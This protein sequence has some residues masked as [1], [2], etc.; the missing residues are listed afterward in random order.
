[1]LQLF[2]FLV[3]LFCSSGILLTLLSN[4]TVITNPPRGSENGTAWIVATSNNEDSIPDSNS[5]T[6]TAE[7]S[8]LLTGFGIWFF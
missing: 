5:N 3:I 2:Q 6:V 7:D 8:P 1:M 4:I